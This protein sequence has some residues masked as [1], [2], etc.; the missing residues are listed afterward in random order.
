MKRQFVQKLHK[1]KMKE[2]EQL[3]ARNALTTDSIRTLS[4]RLQYG[5]HFGSDNLNYLCT[6]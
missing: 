5:Y 3:N 2:I 6:I 4:C 1:F